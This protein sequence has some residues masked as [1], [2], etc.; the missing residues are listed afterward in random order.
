MREAVVCSRAFLGK[1]SRSLRSQLHDVQSASR[2]AFHVSQ[3]GETGRFPPADVDAG[4]AQTHAHLIVLAAPRPERVG[5]AVKRVCV[6]GGVH[7]EY[8]ADEVG[9]AQAV[10][11]GGIAIILYR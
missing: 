10:G 1:L 2:L 6:V 8:A 9:V 3:H 7:A 5:E 4:R 11:S